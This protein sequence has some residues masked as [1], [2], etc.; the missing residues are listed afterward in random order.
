[1]RVV[2]NELLLLK[3]HISANA[4]SSKR[5]VSAMPY[6]NLCCYFLNETN[7]IYNLPYF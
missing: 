6:L 5:T 1:M 4:E 3:T 7:H 2:V